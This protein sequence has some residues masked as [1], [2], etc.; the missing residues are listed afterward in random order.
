MGIRGWRERKKE[1]KY[2]GT[3]EQ[4]LTSEMGNHFNPTPPSPFSKERAGEGKEARR[5]RLR[6]KE[7]QLTREKQEGR[8]RK[9]R[10]VRVDESPS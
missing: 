4:P 3:A 10:G 6:E 5:H 9:K 2:T 1:T 7:R 8:G